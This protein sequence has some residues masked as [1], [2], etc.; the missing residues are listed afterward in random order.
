[1]TWQVKR[2]RFE[3]ETF[4]TDEGWWYWTLINDER[5]VASAS[6][7]AYDQHWSKETALDSARFLKF[8]AAEV[9]IIGGGVLEL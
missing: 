7:E 6:A 3:I 9:P 2:P 4:P 8:H 1:M 5:V